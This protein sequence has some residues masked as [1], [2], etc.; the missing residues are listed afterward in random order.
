MADD[1]FHCPHCK[2]MLRYSTGLQ[3]GTV[4]RCPQCKDTFPVPALGA[5]PDSA[6]ATPP[7]PPAPDSDAGGE[8][9]T[10]PGA[11]RRP[12]RI[13]DEPS[14]PRDRDRRYPDDDDEDH[15]RYHDDYRKRDPDGP[16]SNQYTIDLNRWF[17]YGAAHYTAILGPAVGFMAILIGIT[18]GLSFLGSFMELAL[19]TPFLNL[20]VSLVNQVFITPLFQAG[21]AYVCLRQLDGRPWTF[22]DFF[23]GFRGRFL[24]NIIINSLLMNLVMAP[25][26]GLYVGAVVAL[27]KQ[28]PEIALG[29]LA[30]I[31]VLAIASI[32]FIT[33]LFYFSL[34]LIL[35]RGFNAIDAIKG[36][37][38]LSEGHFWGLF[39]MSLLLGLIGA[40]G[41]CACYIGGLFS[42]PFMVIVQM[43]GYMDVAGIDPPLRRPAPIQQ[44]RENG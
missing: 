15:P 32:Y 9:T 22:A 6:T 36:S 41:I 20:G 13:T 28:A 34:P 40:A 23:A 39:G 27:T 42:I 30:M 8:V 3:P 31:A 12:S 18:I 14:A 11:R 38:T 33:R 25:I 7:T 2:A 5:A 21:L 4:V 37:W 1:T 24:G 29:F 43:A 16:L 35:D 26:F 10:E 44:W 17:S 19:G